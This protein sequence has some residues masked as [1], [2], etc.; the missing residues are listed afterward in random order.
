MKKQVDGWGEIWYHQ[1]INKNGRGGVAMKKII[2]IGII[3][4][5]AGVLALGIHFLRTK[6]YAD[7]VSTGGVV[8][9]VQF[10][11]SHNARRKSYDYTYEICYEYTVGDMVYSGVNTYSGRESDTDAA[12]GKPVTVWYDPDEPGESS[13]HKPGTGLDFIIPFFI[14]LIPIRQILNQKQKGRKRSGSHDR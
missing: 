4:A 14:A 3:L 9:D 7:W 8:T 12:P 13:Y 1:T 5:I 11:R 2:K 6:Q 10:H